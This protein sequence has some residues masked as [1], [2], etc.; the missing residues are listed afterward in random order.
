MPRELIS[1]IGRLQHRFPLLK[2]FL[3]RLTHRIRNETNVIRYGVGVG[4][5]FNPR[6]GN[7]GYAL[8]TT[9]IQEQKAL[10]QWLDEG[11]VFYDIGANKG[12]YAVLGAHLVGEEGHVY[13][14]E[15]FPESAQ[16]IR[17]NVHMNEFENVTVIEAAISDKTGQNELLLTGD[18]ARFRLFSSRNVSPDSKTRS[19]TVRQWSI[20]DLFESK[21]LRS[22]DLVMIDVEGSEIEVLNGMKGIIKTYRPII[23]CEIHWLKWE[24]EEVIA[25]LFEPLGYEVLQL[26]GSE[27][28][29]EITRYHMLMLPPQDADA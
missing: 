2:S 21:P 3:K 26:D 7:P 5:K 13:A 4:L 18:S 1:W 12:F 20:D 22:P 15:P 23:I 14:F 27:L 10:A 28:P 25:D 16:T 24:V 11:N 19:L 17:K 9:E 6:G 29:E 8:G